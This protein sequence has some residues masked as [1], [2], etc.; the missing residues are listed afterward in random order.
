MKKIIKKIKRILGLELPYLLEEEKEEVKEPIVLKDRKDNIIAVP[1]NVEVKFY[2]DT[3]LE[4]QIMLLSNCA[5]NSGITMN[6]AR[7]LVAKL[8]GINI[9]ES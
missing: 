7:K 5:I 4:N 8:G 3:E 2:K 9:N 1:K 6:E